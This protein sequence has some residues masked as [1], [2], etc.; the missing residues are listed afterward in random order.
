MLWCLFNNCSNTR[1]LRMSFS[2]FC[3]NGALGLVE[4]HH[5]LLV[6]LYGLRPVVGLNAGVQAA[7]AHEAKRKELSHGTVLILLFIITH[8]LGRS[9][10]KLLSARKRLALELLCA[11]SARTRIGLNSFSLRRSTFV[12][13]KGRGN[14]SQES[15]TAVQNT[16]TPPLRRTHT[17]TPSTCTHHSRNS[18][19]KSPFGTLRRSLAITLPSAAICY[20]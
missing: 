2:H 11:L 7:K 19:V 10:R 20:I 8:F 14:G 17:H 12:Q 6:V 16:T 5:G 4:K 9:N 1:T 15:T 18:A 3:H 13:L